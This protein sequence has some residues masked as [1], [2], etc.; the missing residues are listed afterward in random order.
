[1]NTWSLKKKLLLLLLLLL[2]PVST[3]A[4]SGAAHTKTIDTPS[5]PSNH[6]GETGCE[7]LDSFISSI[8]SEISSCALSDSYLNE[9]ASKLASCQGVSSLAP[10]A[11]LFSLAPLIQSVND[12]SGGCNA[13]VQRGR[14][15]VASSQLDKACAAFADLSEVR[16]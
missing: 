14:N 3:F 1:M 10:S 2:L 16:K 5:H 11:Q 8:P 6:H 4:L 7:G 9:Y 13:I 15:S 12:C